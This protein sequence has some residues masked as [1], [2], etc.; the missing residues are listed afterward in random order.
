[1]KLL[2]TI[3]LYILLLVV[4]ILCSTVVM[5]ALDCIFEIVHEN[6]WK[7]GFQVGFAAWLI[8]TGFSVVNKIKK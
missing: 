4:M 8:L 2:K 1:M 5:M 7:A 6:I 3:I